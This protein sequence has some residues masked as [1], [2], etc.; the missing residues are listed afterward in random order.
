MMKPAED[1]YRCNSTESSVSSENL[2]N[3]YTI[4]NGPDLIVN[5]KRGFE[6]RRGAS[7]PA[8]KFSC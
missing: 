3:L 2:E 6:S 4:R 5:R 7:F 1:W 8:N